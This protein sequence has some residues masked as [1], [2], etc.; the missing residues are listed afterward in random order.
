MS[1][2]SVLGLRGHKDQQTCHSPGE[3]NLNGY[4]KKSE[5]YHG[6][7]PPPPPSPLSYLYRM[8]NIHQE[9]RKALLHDVEVEV[10]PQFRKKK[11]VKGLYHRAGTDYLKRLKIK[12]QL[13]KWL[14]RTIVTADGGRP[15]GGTSFPREILKFYAPN[16]AIWGYSTSFHKFFFTS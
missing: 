13:R 16:E 5:W 9:E 11:Q 7:P 3:T 10:Y 14:K 12:N 2:R 1:G 6:S 4:E 15:L 8:K